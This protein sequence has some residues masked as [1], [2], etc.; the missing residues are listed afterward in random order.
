M[1]NLAVL[2][3]YNLPKTITDLTHANVIVNSV[4]SARW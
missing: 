2:K 4:V 3:N 1:T